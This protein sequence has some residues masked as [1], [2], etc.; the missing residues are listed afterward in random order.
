MSRDI[1][2]HYDE[3]AG[4]IV[5]STVDQ[6]LTASLRAKAFPLETSV[7]AFKA[8][9]PDEAERTLGAGIFALLDLSC[10]PKIGIRDYK[11]DTAKWDAENTKEL[12]QKSATG[13]GAAQFDLAME[14]ITQ[15]LLK[16]SKK[17]MNE[18]DSLL[19]SAVA[20]GHAEAAEYSVNLWPS[21]K[22]RSDKSFK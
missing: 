20:A 6:A 9:G 22:E 1:I 4:M 15:G 11:A 5:C 19:Q 14:K 3:A 10:D 21:L 12:E 18:A 16:K 8:R 2:V 13:D 7:D 17:L